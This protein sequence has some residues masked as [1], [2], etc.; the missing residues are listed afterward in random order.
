MAREIELKLSLP[1]TEQ[2][3]FLR[4]ALLRHASGRSTERLVNIYYDTPDLALHPAQGQSKG[5]DRLRQDPLPPAPQD[6]E[7]ARPP[8]GLA[9]HRTS[10]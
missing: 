6:R 4:S 2:Q 3:R 8:Q 5:P 10:L 1:E 9:A 7:H